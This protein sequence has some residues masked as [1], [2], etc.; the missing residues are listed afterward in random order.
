MNRLGRFGPLEKNVAFARLCPYR[1]CY[2]T[3]VLSDAE[4]G[5]ARRHLPSAMRGTG[6]EASG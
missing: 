4:S 2:G 5:L 1:K 6:A 3:Q